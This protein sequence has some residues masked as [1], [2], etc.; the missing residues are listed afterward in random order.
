[1]MMIIIITITI[2]IIIQF[3]VYYCASSTAEGPPKNT[4]HTIL[5]ENHIQNT[6]Q[7]WIYYRIRGLDMRTQTVCPSGSVFTAKT[8]EICFNYQLD[9]QFLYSVIYVLH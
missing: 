7:G 4:Q 9:A 6:Y 2:I 1:M 8:R 5:R 3:L